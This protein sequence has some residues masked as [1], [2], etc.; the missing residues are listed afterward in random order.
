MIDDKCKLNE[1]ELSNISAGKNVDDIVNELI[2]L[3]SQYPE[4]VEI[5]DAYE[6]SDYGKLLML[7]QEFAIAHPELAS[8]FD[9]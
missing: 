3:A 4:I 8:I 6:K 5:I 1:E 9:D 7:L 2:P